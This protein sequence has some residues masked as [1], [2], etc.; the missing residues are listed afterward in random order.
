MHNTLFIIV[1]HL[2]GSAFLSYCVLT[3]LIC[4]TISFCK[5]DYRY[6][7]ILDNQDNLVVNIEI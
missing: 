4:K 7:E 6:Q 5:C 1:G 3:A 2:D